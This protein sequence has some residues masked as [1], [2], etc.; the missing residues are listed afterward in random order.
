M[1]VDASLDESISRGLWLVKWL[2]LIRLDMGGNDLGS[3]PTDLIPPSPSGIPVSAAP[4]P[5]ATTL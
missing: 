5:A 3:V 2:L 4:A 1:R